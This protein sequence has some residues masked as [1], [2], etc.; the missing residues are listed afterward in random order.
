[1]LSVAVGEFA[2]TVIKL[3]I[4]SPV[5]VFPLRHTQWLLWFL[6]IVSDTITDVAAESTPK[7]LSSASSK[8]LERLFSSV[9]FDIAILTPF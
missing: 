8:K 5:V 6:G 2:D 1:M 4:S 3:V 7:Y 9:C